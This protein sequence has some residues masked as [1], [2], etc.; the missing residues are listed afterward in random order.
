MDEYEVN[1]A[2]YLVVLWRKKWIVALTFLVSV[3]AAF[4]WTTRQPDTYRVDTALLILP[5][6]AA[7]IADEV[8]GTVYSPETYVRLA[9]ARDLLQVAVERAYPEGSTLS[10]SEL[11]GRMNVELDDRAA[12]DFPGRF[13]LYMRT[14]FTGGDREELPRL[15]DAWAEAFVE[16]NAELFVSRIAQSYDYI[17]ESFYEVEGE[18]RAKQ[19]QLQK[20]QEESQEELLEAELAALDDVYSGS[21]LDLSAKRRELAQLESRL[22]LLERFLEDPVR[23]ALAGGTLSGAYSSYSADLISKERELSQL[24]GRLAS[25][26]SALVEEPEQYLLSRGVSVEAL[27]QFLGREADELATE[28][29]ERFA[30]LAVRDQVLNQTYV[31]LRGAVASA[32]ADLKSVQADIAYLRDQTA[33]LGEV[34]AGGNADSAGLTEIVSQVE[35][36]LRGELAAGEARAEELRADVSLLEVQ[37]EEAKQGI[38]ERRSR[39]IAVDAET[40]RLEQEI[41]VL[42]RNYERMADKLQDARAARA[43]TAEPIRVVEAALPETV[44]TISPGRTMNVAVAGVLGLFA[45]V[46]LAFVAHAV[47]ERQAEMASAG[48]GSERALG[49]EPSEPTVPNDRDKD[50]EPQR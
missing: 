28:D 41:Q 18:L 36:E 38:E 25:L 13:P 6:L 15:A 5:P 46:L 7:D 14:T 32:R 16:K 39:L 27:W 2:D 40:R 35:Y 4:A 12:R 1:L 45:G 24:E 26:E 21:L 10:P 49:S 22:A 11:H 33:A 37:A 42:E 23:Y 31:E 9:T 44:R 3:G 17:S 48:G 19:D 29:L 20:L 34:L 50:S 43:E 30:A 47:Q 8:P